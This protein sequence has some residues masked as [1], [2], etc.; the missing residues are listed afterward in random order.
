MAV[1]CLR[2][3][4][5][6]LSPLSSSSLDDCITPWIT[7]SGYF[8]SIGLNRL[9]S[10]AAAPHKKFI[11]MSSLR[12]GTIWYSR[13]DSSRTQY[14]LKPCT[15]LPKMVFFFTKLSKCRRKSN[16]L[17]HPFREFENCQTG[18]S[19]IE[20]NLLEKEIIAADNLNSATRKSS[21][22]GHCVTL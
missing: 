7:P 20:V 16:K 6:F 12:L 8:L 18:K 4:L 9:S 3:W 13:N 1:V 19:T 21:L 2:W 5:S 14:S 11:S 15:P 17:D 22:K 10:L